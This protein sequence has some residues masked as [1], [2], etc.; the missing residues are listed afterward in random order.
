MDEQESHILRELKQGNHSALK[1]IFELYYEPLVRYA[2]RVTHDRE[3]SR[4]IIQELFIAI[5]QNR[6]ELKLRFRLKTYLFSAAHHRALNWVRHKKVEEKVREKSWADLLDS[7][8]PPPDVQPFMAY[9]IETAVE[10]LPDRMKSVFT[11]TQLLGKSY[12]EA[13]IQLGISPKT[14]EN[15]LIRARKQLRKDL[16][17]YLTT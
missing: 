14:V 12:K 4:E 16:A 10:R 6:E 11:L 17:D 9:H 7:T 2:G 3:A 13:A 8:T 1:K 15:L 5:W